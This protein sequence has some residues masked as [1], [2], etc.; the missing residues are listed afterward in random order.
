ML[1]FLHVSYY[2][3]QAVVAAAGSAAAGGGSACLVRAAGGRPRIPAA[4]ASEQG[5]ISFPA[6]AKCLSFRQG[7]CVFLF[8]PKFVSL[9][10]LDDNLIDVIANQTNHKVAPRNSAVLFNW[11]SFKKTKKIFLPIL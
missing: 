3:C 8:S 7:K 2:M 6:H 1:F 10:I 4:F 5:L 9:S 11:I